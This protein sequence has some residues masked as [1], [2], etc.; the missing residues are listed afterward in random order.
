MAK[1]E[2]TITFKPM[3]EWVLEGYKRNVLEDIEETHIL[4][5]VKDVFFFTKGYF[6]RKDC[7]PIEA[8]DFIA[9]LI[10]DGKIR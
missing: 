3:P 9:S 7:I 5:T 2:I 10:M 8:M 6:C 1:Q 4:T